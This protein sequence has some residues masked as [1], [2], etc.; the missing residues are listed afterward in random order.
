M[1]SEISY[2][3]II[4]FVYFIILCYSVYYQVLNSLSMADERERVIVSV[5]IDARG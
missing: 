4:S 3:S 2:T 5:E 1:T